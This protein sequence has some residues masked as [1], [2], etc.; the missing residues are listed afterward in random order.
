MHICVS[1]LLNLF[2]YF[3]LFA[4]SHRVWI[5]ARDLK[6]GNWD[7][8]QPL[9]IPVPKQLY[10]RYGYTNLYQNNFMDNNYGRYGY[11]DYGTNINYQGINKDYK[12]F[13][14]L[15][16]D[17]VPF[18]W[19][20]TYEY[21]WYYPARTKFGTSVA[22]EKDSII[23]G[24]WSYQ[25]VFFYGKFPNGEW[26]LVPIKVI[27]KRVIDDAYRTK[28]QIQISCIS[29]GPGGGN[30]YGFTEKD[31]KRCEC[32]PGGA[33]KHFTY[34]EQ[35]GAEIKIAGG[36]VMISSSLGLPDKIERPFVDGLTSE[37]DYVIPPLH[38]ND[39]EMYELDEAAPHYIKLTS[40]EKNCEDG[41]Y[42]T[43]HTREECQSAATY[44]NLP[45]Q[46]IKKN[47]Y[48]WIITTAVH[49]FYVV[50]RSVCSS[51]GTGCWDGNIHPNGT[52][53]TQQAYQNYKSIDTKK[54]CGRFNLFLDFKTAAIDVY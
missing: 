10:G 15:D 24:D 49:Y 36:Q 40:N 23:I 6:D 50:E 37:Q 41:G 22:H 3:S 20:K 26:N 48:E 32:G 27:D 45:D 4:Q 33:R 39:I 52:I 34:Y 14:M 28:D 54:E 53:V 7:T 1:I 2:F 5:F 29:V 21:F 47:H 42:S 19:C 35:Y 9:E 31:Q 12:I 38:Y 30:G 8:Q 46:K 17:F 44:L 16:T 51:V 43:I 11:T 13:S 25:K 18:K